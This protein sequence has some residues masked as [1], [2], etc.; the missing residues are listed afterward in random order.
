MNKLDDLHYSVCPASGL[1]IFTKDLEECVS[2]PTSEDSVILHPMSL[3]DSYASVTIMVFVL[4]SVFT[5]NITDMISLSFSSTIL[6]IVSKQSS[7]MLLTPAL[8]AS[9]VI[10]GLVRSSILELLSTALDRI[11]NN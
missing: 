7:E 3:S 11:K 1:V 8:R 5:I 6:R 9:L 10:E 4:C 2:V